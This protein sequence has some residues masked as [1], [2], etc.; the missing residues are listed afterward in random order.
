MQMVEMNETK[1]PASMIV[2]K[3]ELQRMII[4]L[5]VGQMTLPPPH[6]LAQSVPP[7]RSTLSHAQISTPGASQQ[8]S[9]PKIAANVYRKKNPL[10]VAV[11]CIATVALS[12]LLTLAVAAA[13][14]ALTHSIPAAQAVGQAGILVSGL[15]GVY[16][17][18]RAREHNEGLPTNGARKDLP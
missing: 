5:P 13:V 12:L 16:V 10:V 17:L 18:I 6:T 14:S 1:R 15:A 4:Q 11:T 8:V 3:Q 9:T 7:V 2:V